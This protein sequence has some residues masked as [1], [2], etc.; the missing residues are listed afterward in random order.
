MS[1]TQVIEET[2]GTK[3]R[4]IYALKTLIELVENDRIRA[5]EISG[6]TTDQII[7]LAEAKAD[8]ALAVAERLKNS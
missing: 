2:A 7:E 4:I 5:G 1:K 6:L 8:E 3:E